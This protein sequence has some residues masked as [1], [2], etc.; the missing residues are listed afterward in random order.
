MVVITPWEMRIKKIE[1]HFG[2]G[3]ASYFVFLRW[4]FW[5]NLFIS[6]FICC[7]LMVPEVS[8]L[9]KML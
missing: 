4:V 7:F 9:L 2:S 8:E 6:V 1:S 3:V 5:V